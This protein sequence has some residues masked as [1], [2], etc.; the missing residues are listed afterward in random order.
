M[1]AA[2]L[3]CLGAIGAGKT[4][5]LKKIQ[6]QNSTKVE[7]HVVEESG[8]PPQP[9]PTVGINHFDINL[10]T[11]GDQFQNN[12][13]QNTN[14]FSICIVPPKSHKNNSKV[15]LKEF[16][17]ELT[18]AWKSYLQGLLNEH[19]DKSGVLYLIDVSNISRLSEAGVHLMETIETFEKLRKTSTRVLIVFSK[20][21]LLDS[22][23]KTKIL[24]EAKNILRYVTETGS[25]YQHVARSVQIF[26]V[27]LHG[28]QRQFV[29]YLFLKIW[30]IK[31]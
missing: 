8:L 17:G 21:D 19:Y 31:S 25:V 4:T 23:S 5:L 6:N 28:C 22:V 9:L 10:T 16:G 15:E 13:P 12:P 29:S 20:V 27:S 2:L 3:V 24:N 14:C 30:S 1:P 26:L 7:V 11:S 18:P